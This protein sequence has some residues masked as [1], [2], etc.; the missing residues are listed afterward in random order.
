MIYDQVQIYILVDI[1]PQLPTDYPDNR[2]NSTCET[3]PQVRKTDGPMT[4][5]L[6]ILSYR[7]T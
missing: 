7:L 6:S 5:E 1:A 2:A 4:T 3:T